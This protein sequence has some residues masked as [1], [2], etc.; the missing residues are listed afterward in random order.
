MLKSINLNYDDHTE[1]VDARESYELHGPEASD[2]MM[3]LFN[4]MITAFEKNMTNKALNDNDRKVLDSIL[5]LF[6]SH[7]DHKMTKEEYDELESGNN[8][9]PDAYKSRML[10]TTWQKNHG[11]G[12][13]LDDNKYS[14]GNILDYIADRSKLSKEEMSKSLT[15]LRNLYKDKKKDFYNKDDKN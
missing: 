10:V 5:E 13:V 7:G 11:T 6:K 15:K 9:S 2:E 3:D 14:K 8:D 12:D 4:H 1:E